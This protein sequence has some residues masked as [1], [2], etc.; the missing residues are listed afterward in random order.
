MPQRA[1][2][3]HFVQHPSVAL[4]PATGATCDQASQGTL[5]ST[6][7]PHHTMKALVEMSD[8]GNPTVAVAAV[9]QREQTP[10]TGA[11]PAALT[12][13]MFKRASAVA[14]CSNQRRKSACA[15]FGAWGTEGS[16]ACPS[17]TT[18]AAKPMR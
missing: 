1:P 8:Q 11:G 6:E 2:R 18:M 7:L 4:V 13:L 16:M 15:S 17:A 3:R 10:A 9:Q 12:P 14:G 5:P